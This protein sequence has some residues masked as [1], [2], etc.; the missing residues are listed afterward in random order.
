MQ[1]NIFLFH[2]NNN[3]YNIK[4]N[5]IQKRFNNRIKMKIEKYSIGI[6]DRFGLE[7]SAQLRAL[8]QAEVLGVKI[9]PV[10]NKSNREHAII[11]TLP[12]DAKRGADLAVKTCGWHASY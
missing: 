10:W 11:G 2:I 7:G 5:L 3:D 12:E 6:G 9:V 4:I 1:K 8:Q